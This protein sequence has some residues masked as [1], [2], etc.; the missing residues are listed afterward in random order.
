MAFFDNL[1]QTTLVDLSE[2]SVNLPIDADRF[3][4]VVPE[5]VDV[6]G[7]PAVAVTLDP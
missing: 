5:D 7:V 2:V 4:F 3:N 1:E 6:V